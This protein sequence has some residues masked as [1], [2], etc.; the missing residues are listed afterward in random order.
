MCCDEVLQKTRGTSF[1]NVVT[2]H[3]GG[4]EREGGGLR[5]AGMARRRAREAM[6]TG[7]SLRRAANGPADVSSAGPARSRTRRAL[8]T[9]SSANWQLNVCGDQYTVDGETGD[10]RLDPPDPA[11]G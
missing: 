3:Q 2:L 11:T 9:A 1:H 7:P 10:L 4:L 8:A 5:A 6:S